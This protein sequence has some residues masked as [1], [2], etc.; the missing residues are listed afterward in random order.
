MGF[1]MEIL[2]SLFLTVVTRSVIRVSQW[3]GFGGTA[4]PGVWVEKYF[5]SLISRYAKHYKKIIFITGTNGK[6][7]VQLALGKVLGS[8]GYRVTGNFSGSNMLRGIATTLLAAGIP[9]QDM[10]VLLCEVE[11]ATMPIITRYIHP[12]SIV[13]TN[14]YRD[15]LDAYG[16]LD[17]TAEYIKTACQNSPDATLVLN[18][19]DPVIIRLSTALPHKKT[20]YSLGEYAKQFQYEGSPDDMHEIA[21]SVQ[22]TIDTPR[23]DASRES[24]NENSLSFSIKVNTPTPAS[25]SRPPVT[26]MEGSLSA[27]SADSVGMTGISNNETRTRDRT[28][29]II[30]RS[31]VVNDD[32]STESQVESRGKTISLHFKP[33]GMYNVYN[34]LA[35]YTVAQGFG[36]QDDTIISTLANVQPPFGRGELVTF[37][38][39]GKLHIFQIFLVKN[40]AGYSQVWEML[41]Q[42]KTPFNLILGLNDNIADGRDVSWIWD[43]E[44]GQFAHSDTVQLVS[45]TGRRA[46]D[47]ALR[48][49][50]AEIAATTQNITPDIPTSLENILQ[51]STDGRRTFVL[52]T[53]TAMNQFRT[54]LGQYVTLLPYTS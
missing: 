29:D 48:L 39:D 24:H 32:L 53:Y 25:S 20:T 21:S 44:L 37:R 2:I 4:L 1:V 31:I 28:P 27:D 15:Q 14:M 16:E 19:D 43:I 50:Y 42:I 22:S 54:A 49:K 7:T 52:M 3:L 41:R 34:V 6:T 36:M 8:A 11:E 46:Y 17:K 13:I 38:K 51:R 47:M 40:P 5:P 33:P 35:V 30:A 10:S 9:T 12:D 23:N 18:G 45:F 26:G